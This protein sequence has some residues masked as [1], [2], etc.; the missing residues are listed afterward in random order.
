M[1]SKDAE[2][3]VVTQDRKRAVLA[4]ESSLT[5]LD[6]ASGIVRHTLIGHSARVTALVATPD[7]TEVISGSEDHTIK[8]WNLAS[9]T[10]RYTLVGHSGSVTALVVTP[11]A[12]YVVSASRDKTLKVWDL[13][14]G[15]ILDSYA[16]DVAMLSCALAPGNETVI[17]EDQIGGVHILRLLGPTDRLACEDLDVLMQSVSASSGDFR[18]TAASRDRSTRTHR[19]V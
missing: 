17:A 11:D 9:G 1:R 14:S 18:I 19:L 10:E 4:R 5:V 13:T 8:V 15:L 16:G 12:K 7:G 6:L 3:M 2:V